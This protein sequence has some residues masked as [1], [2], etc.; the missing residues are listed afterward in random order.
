[1]ATDENGLSREELTDSGVVQ[2]DGGEDTVRNI[3][4]IDI[5]NECESNLEHSLS[6]VNG[7]SILSSADNIAGTIT[8]E[9]SGRMMMMAVRDGATGMIRRH[10]LR[11]VI[12]EE[13][14]VL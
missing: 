5:E 10:L 11:K 6:T 4:V 14:Y 3:N 8:P 9:S 2:G 13:I 12:I 1:M 7:Q